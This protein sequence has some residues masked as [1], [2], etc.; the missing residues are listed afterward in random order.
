MFSRTHNPIGTV[1]RL[2]QNTSDGDFQTRRNA[3]RQYGR[4]SEIASVL[5]RA[6]LFTEAIRKEMETF[7]ALKQVFRGKDYSTVA[8]DDGKLNSPGVRRLATNA[9]GA[10]PHRWLRLTA[11]RKIPW[12]FAGR[13]MP[14]VWGGPSAASQAAFD[15]GSESP[16]RDWESRPGG[17]SVPHG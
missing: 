1:S 9:A 14:T 8:G 11:S 7:D 5:H 6:L 17:E 15:T 12:Q 13:S 16:G 10:Q 4:L 2:T 3:H